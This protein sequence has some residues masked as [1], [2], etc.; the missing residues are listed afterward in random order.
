MTALGHSDTR[1]T[2]CYLGLDYEDQS[3]A[4]TKYAQF[5][6]DLVAQKWALFD[7]ASSVSGQ[8]GI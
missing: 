6:K 2:I 3:N 1:T 7:K 4:M 8:R 5:Q